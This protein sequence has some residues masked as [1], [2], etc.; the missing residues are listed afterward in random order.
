MALWRLLCGA[1]S[2]EERTNWA[3]AL[4][5]AIDKAPLTGWLK[6]RGERRGGLMGRLK[7]VG[8]EELWCELQPPQGEAEASFS[9]YRAQGDAAAVDTAPF[10][11][12]SQVEL[13]SAFAAKG[14]PHVLVLSSP[15]FFAC[16]SRTDL[17]RWRRGINRSLRSFH[18]HKGPAV[19]LTKEEK[20]LHG[21][22]VQQ[23]KLMLEYLGVDVDPRCEDKYKLCLLIV[24]QREVS[25]LAK[26]KGI[27]DTAELMEKIRKDEERLKHRSVEELR[28]LLEYMEVEFDEELDDPD[29]LIKLIIN[30]K[31]MHAVS[32]ALG[33]GLRRWRTRSRSSLKLAGPASSAGDPVEIQ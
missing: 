4:D 31:N 23:L 30:Q 19:S 27:D 14:M 3:A 5:E 6:R 13:S 29:R 22:S 33:P 2:K 32:T 24:K 9:L 8:W 17:E 21:K 26:K 18:T 20:E 16:S 7:K 15:T 11:K 28:Q 12:D 25:L 10:N 1:A